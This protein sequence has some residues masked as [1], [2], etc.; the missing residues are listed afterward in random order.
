MVK[1]T[2]ERKINH[3]R[4]TVTIRKRFPDG[5]MTKYRTY[6]DSKKG[7]EWWNFVTEN[8]IQH[9]LSHTND[10]YIVK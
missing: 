2:L 4:R 6:P 7:I 9:F 3:S 1:V 10:Y 5:T 8:D